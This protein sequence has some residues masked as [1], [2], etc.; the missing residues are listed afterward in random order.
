MRPVQDQMAR[1]RTEY[2]A[3]GRVVAKGELLELESGP[4][5]ST[6]TLNA[7]DLRSFGPDRSENANLLCKD[8]TRLGEKMPEVVFDFELSPHLAWLRESAFPERLTALV[9]CELDDGTTCH[10]WVITAATSDILSVR[11]ADDGTTRQLRLRR[12]NDAAVTVPAD[13]EATQRKCL[14][15]T[16]QA[17]DPELEQAWARCERARFSPEK[18]GDSSLVLELAAYLQSIDDG[19]A[20]WKNPS[21]LHNK[22]KERKQS[23]PAAFMFSKARRSAEE[24]G[25]VALQLRLF[26][27]WHLIQIGRADDALEATSVV[28]DPSVYR[29]SDATQLSI[30]L[31]HRGRCFADVGRLDEAER[32]ARAALRIGYSHFATNLLKRIKKEQ[33]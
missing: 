12:L 14:A 33:C 7:T 15:S 3:S 6:Y 28:D 9:G 30:V 2:A 21:D 20:H 19:T 23:R 4:P 11:D 16:Q 8:R 29:S 27:S 5:D 25:A 26:E 17:R 24:S 10:E 31:T 18:L 22:L 32:C 13:L 1:R